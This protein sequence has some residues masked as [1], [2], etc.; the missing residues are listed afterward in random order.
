MRRVI[1]SEIRTIVRRL[2]FSSYFRENPAEKR[3][4]PTE[5]AFINL[6]HESGARIISFSLRRATR[7]AAGISHYCIKNYQIVKTDNTK[8]SLYIP[9]E[10]RGH[11]KVHVARGAQY[12]KV[13]AY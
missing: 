10:T 2:L 8:C 5:T 12:I 1:F 3:G 6:A 13:L 4:T 9:R 11:E 7:I